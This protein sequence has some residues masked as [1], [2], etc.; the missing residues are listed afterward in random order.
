MKA[1]QAHTNFLS[2]F[3]SR[4]WLHADREDAAEREAVEIGLRKRWLRRELSEA[5][6]TPAG[7]AAL[8]QG[9]QAYRCEHCGIDRLTSCDRAACPHTSRAALEHG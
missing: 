5:H 3:V 6:F 2:R 8:E 9:S 7:R 1:T 4:G